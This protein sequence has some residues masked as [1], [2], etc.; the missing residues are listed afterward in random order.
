[1]GPYSSKECLDEY[2]PVGMDLF[3]PLYTAAPVNYRP[4]VNLLMHF[5]YFYSPYTNSYNAKVCKLHSAYVVENGKLE[6]VLRRRN[7]DDD[8][9][10]GRNR[11]RLPQPAGRCCS[12]DDVRRPSSVSPG[13]QRAAVADAN[14]HRGGDA[15]PH[16]TSLSRDLMTTSGSVLTDLHATLTVAYLVS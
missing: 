16:V 8:D 1:M 10:D 5:L 6:S 2:G 9:S 3:I 13:R 12:A 15:S 14:D 4:T 7:D 11:H